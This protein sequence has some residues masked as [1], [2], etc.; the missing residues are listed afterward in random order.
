VFLNLVLGTKELLPLRTFD[1][2]SRIPMANRNYHTMA[3]WEAGEREKAK[4]NC[5]LQN[6]ERETQETI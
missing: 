2:V 6:T 1:V 3:T 5:L 4:N